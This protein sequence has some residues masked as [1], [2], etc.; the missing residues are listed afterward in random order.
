MKFLKLNKFVVYKCEMHTFF[1]FHPIFSHLATNRI[2]IF[3]IPKTEILIKMWMHAL[4]SY[5][6]QYNCC[7]YVVNVLGCR[8]LLCYFTC[9][10][11]IQISISNKSLTWRG[12]IFGQ[13]QTFLSRQN[14]D[15]LLRINQQADAKAMYSIFLLYALLLLLGVLHFREIEK[16]TIP[17]TRA[18]ASGCRWPYIRFWVANIY[19]YISA[20]SHH[21]LTTPCF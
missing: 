17:G 18:E 10:D 9:R 20:F 16:K 2:K 19:D 12:F 1:T 3:W 21:C 5:S 13:K 14:E 15:I 8:C 4:F 6:L 11:V 7:E